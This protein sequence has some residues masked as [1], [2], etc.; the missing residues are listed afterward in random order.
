MFVRTQANESNLLAGSLEELKDIE[1]DVVSLCHVLKR[2][3][4][5]IEELD[6]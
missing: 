3:I 2:S 4:G 5:I 1:K 6:S